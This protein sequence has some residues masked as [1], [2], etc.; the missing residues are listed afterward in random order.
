VRLERIDPVDADQSVA[1]LG[2]IVLTPL[3]R[4]EER[5]KRERAREDRRRRE[6]ARDEPPPEPGRVDIRA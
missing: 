1:P 5:R 2:A 3:Q 4:D 6:E